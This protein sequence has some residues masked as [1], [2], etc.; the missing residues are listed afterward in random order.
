M[1]VELPDPPQTGESDVDEAML[2]LASV[3]GATLDEQLAVLESV[4]RTLQDR[5]ADVDG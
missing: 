4:H 2:R 1:Q 3:T 5:L